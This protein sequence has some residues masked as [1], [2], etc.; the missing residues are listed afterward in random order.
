MSLSEWI[1]RIDESVDEAVRTLRTIAPVGR[2]AWL[3]RF[4]RR[5]AARWREVFAEQ[6]TIEEV[7]SLVESITATVQT[8]LADLERGGAQTLH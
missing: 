5:V 2:P 8:R 3:G 7:D 1:D 6:L 4:Q